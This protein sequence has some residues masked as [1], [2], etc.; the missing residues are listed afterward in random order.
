[1]R[2]FQ[3]TYRNRRLTGSPDILPPW[4]IVLIA[5]S[6][7][8]FKPEEG[9]PADAGSEFDSISTIHAIADALESD[10]HCVHILEA[11]SS[12]P[13]A[14]IKARPQICFNIAEGL[15]G[16]G[17]EAHVPA[18]CE[19]MGI[20]YTASRVVPSA[21]SLDKTI[22]KRIW[23]DA[24]LPTA[25]FFEAASQADIDQ[26]TLDFP[27]FVKPAREGSGMGI[28][29]ASIVTNFEELTSKVDDITRVYRQPALIEQYLPGREF[30][31]GFIGNPGSPDFRHSK[32][33]YDQEGFHW[34]P[35]MEIDSL[36]S[37]SPAVYGQESKTKDIGAEGAPDYLCP[38]D[39]PDQLKNDLI[40]LTKRAAQILEVCDV[41]RVDIR[42]GADQKPYLLEINTLPGLNP[43]LS[44]LCIM[45]AAEG[46]NYRTLI[47]EILY[48]AADRFQ[49]PLPEKRTGRRTGAAGP[50][51]KVRQPA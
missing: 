32:A 27:L 39:I 30:T 26:N 8:D 33:L 46:M 6:K 29:Q 40:T 7:A 47:T 13:S 44:D 2:I 17:R 48:L 43:D 3:P 35:V 24:G 36:N 9:D 11:D 22:T 18:L 19:L 28:T 23:R 5:N 50:S 4:R 20:P 38:A 25:N 51:V 15:Q 49:M 10:G 21:I 41:S 14:I 42:L 37:V 16:N 45:A 34:F 12:L 1:M 31:V